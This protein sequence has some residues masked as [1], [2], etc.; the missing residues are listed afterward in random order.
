MTIFSTYDADH[1]NHLRK[2]FIKCRRY[3]LSLY[4]KRSHFSMEEGKLLG[5]IV[6]KDGVKIE[7]ERV[8]VIHNIPFPR[9]KK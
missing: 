4:P 6:S 1:I 5:H 9:N 8:V 3:N 7:P 2:T